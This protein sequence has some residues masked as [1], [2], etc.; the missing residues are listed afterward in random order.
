MNDTKRYLSN[1]FKVKDMGEASYVIG[2][3]I[4][5]NRPQGLLGLSQK[6]HINNV[7]ERFRMEKCSTSLVQIQK[8]DKFSINQCPKN[9]LEHK[10][11]NDVTYA[12]I[13][14]SLMYAQAYTRPDISF[15]G[16]MLGRYQSNQGMDHW[17][18]TKKVL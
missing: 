5:R 11:M 3:E 8:E 9:E 4:F 12:S 16:G 1:N 17:K 7:L 15:V 14:G 10:Q 13:V 6:A 2:I 18:A